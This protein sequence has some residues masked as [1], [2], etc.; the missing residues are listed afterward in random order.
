MKQLN[1]KEIKS[2]Y[3]KAFEKWQGPR[4]DDLGCAEEY[5]DVVTFIGPDKEEFNYLDSF[6]N[7]VRQFTSESFYY[8]RNLLGKKQYRWRI[9]SSN[10]RIIAMSSEGYSNLADLYRSTVIVAE[11]LEGVL[12]M[13]TIPIHER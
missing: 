7:N 5:F 6:R 11:A 3:P 1:W 4:V 10:G 8:K 13:K 9:I 2:N 12:D